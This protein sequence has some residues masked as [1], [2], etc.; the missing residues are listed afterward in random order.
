MKGGQIRA[1]VTTKKSDSKKSRAN[2]F[3]Y[4]SLFLRKLQTPLLFPWDNNK[5]E[6][7]TW[8][9]NQNFIT[10]IFPPMDVVAVNFPPPNNN[11]SAATSTTLSGKKQQKK[12]R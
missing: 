1:R 6:A 12:R 5:K 8:H 7:S 3:D 2:E 4:L 11:I 10:Q 9:E